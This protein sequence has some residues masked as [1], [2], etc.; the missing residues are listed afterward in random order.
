MQSGVFSSGGVLAFTSRV[1]VNGVTRSHDSWSLDREISGDLPS[2]V[3]YG[4]GIRQA[5]GTIAWSLPSVVAG[6]PASP[7]RRN[8]WVP[9][10]GD[11]VVIWQGDGVSEW[12]QFTGVIDRTAGTVGE[13]FESRIIDDYDK[14]AAPIQ[15]EAML[16]AMP[17]LNP[18][19]PFR[20]VGLTQIYYVDR[21]AR[22]GGFYATPAQAPACVLHVP[23]NGSLWP[24]QGTCVT[25]ESHSAAYP[26]N[27]FAP[28]GFASGDFTATYAPSSSLSA[29]TPVQL[30]A[31][32]APSHAGF[33]Y[34]RAAYGSTYV[35][36]S[37]NSNWQLVARIGTTQVAQFTLTSLD[38]VVQ[39]LVKNGAVTLRATTGQSATGTASFSGAE[40][41]G[42]ITIS[43]D[44]AS[45]V[46][47]MQISH[48]SVA[49]EFREQSFTR[50]AVF[51]VADTSL[52]GIIPAIPAIKSQT[53]ASLLDE[54]ST[55]TLSACWIDEL[56]VLRWW[57]AKSFL[58]RSPLGSITTARD[59]FAMSWEESLQSSAS[60]V[61]VEY[62]DP[63]VRISQD[64]TVELW[65]GNGG[66]LS[67]SEEQIDF[68]GPGTDEAWYGVDSSLQR[69]S[70]ANWDLL[71]A[72][73]QS[74]FGAYFM[75]NGDVISEAGLAISATMV[76]LGVDRFKVRQYVSAM[77]A[78]TTAVTRARDD[79]L[80]IW[81]PYRGQDLPVVRGHGLTTWEDTVY[82]PSQTV[83]RGVELV[84]ETGVWIPPDIISRVFDYLREQTAEPAPVIR[85]LEVATDPRRQVGDVTVVRSEAFLGVTLTVLIVGLTSSHTPGGSS[86]VLDVRVIDVDVNAQTYAQFDQSLVDGLTYQQW[87]A[88]TSQNY[89]TFNQEA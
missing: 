41:M 84:H 14:L 75:R 54:L 77:P 73:N 11:R 22:A 26:A 44:A 67:S 63:T 13:G 8:V 64:T 82:S 5:T 78:G 40:T 24:H 53:A 18:G 66:S 23:G 56:G 25:C 52:M 62:K 48:P 55:R 16:A 3:A 57:P 83:R 19:G 80:D 60:T 36:M 27:R 17:P 88:I 61:A 72:P 29:S 30:T 51:N 34:M 68:V 70:N 6:E 20:R 76:G 37:V 39:M 12:A 42:T 79:L 2:Q 86:Q 33:W 9:Q 59:V 43:G 28:W 46:G 47:G 10:R 32:I 35:Q 31:V 65:R 45:A 49:Q 81:L 85:G 87:N 89:Q 21:A 74:F 58:L 4:A 15:H 7:W 69:V 1:T 50:S 71:N 38:T